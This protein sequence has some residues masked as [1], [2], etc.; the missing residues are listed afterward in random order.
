[1]RDVPGARTHADA[2][3]DSRD[4]RR[5]LECAHGTI[6]WKCYL[7]TSLT[8]ADTRHLVPGAADHANG[9]PKRQRPSDQVSE[10]I[11]VFTTQTEYHLCA[12]PNS[13]SFV[14]RCGQAA[15]KCE[16]G[17]YQFAATHHVRPSPD[18]YVSAVA[19][20]QWDERA[21]GRWRQ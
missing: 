19:D 9:M 13:S 10:L 16:L 18:E 7:L 11:A 12:H 5:T 1:M 17:E 20:S 6:R 4:L 21:F 14:V 2:R 15:L 3:P 8:Q